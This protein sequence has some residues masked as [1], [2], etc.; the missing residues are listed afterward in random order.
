M[1]IESSNRENNTENIVKQDKE[2]LNVSKQSN[3]EVQDKEAKKEEITKKIEN[4][5]EKLNE[6]RQKL[7]LSN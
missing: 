1:G 6:L 3:K 7:G 4:E 5:K 2:D